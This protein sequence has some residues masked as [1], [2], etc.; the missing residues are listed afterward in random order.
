MQNIENPA[1]QKAAYITVLVSLVV[2]GL[3]FWAFYLT[4]SAAVFSDALETVVNVV[5]AFTGLAVISYT[6]KPKDE[7]H[8]YG[9]GKVEYFSAAFEGA[10]ILFASVTILVESVQVLLHPRELQ[11]L[12]LGIVCITVA[13]AINF[14]TALYLRRVG[15]KVKSETLMASSSHIMSD[16]WTTAGVVL[17]LALVRVTGWL[18]V[19]G[20]VTLVLA[21]VLM[22]E[23]YKIVRRSIS[24]L[25]DEMD[26]PSLS[27]LSESIQKNRRPGII[28]IHNLRTIRAGSFHH[29][30]AHLVVPE[31]WDVAQAHELAHVFEEAVVNDYPYDGEF[32]FHL[33]PCQRK[34]CRYCDVKN[35]PIRQEP[36]EEA[37]SF[38][39]KDMICG[40]LENVVGGAE[41]YSK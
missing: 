40:P 12:D 33:D 17:G 4:K 38:S 24:G 21:F 35:C 5:T 15:H 9:H 11:K 32:A 28:D 14:F 13:S 41:N 8:P 18:W 27:S 29:I 25:T 26:D 30:D 36:F 20:V 22:N 34:Y 2:L 10:L 7:D 1:R 39:V 16:V 37:R 19:D 31:F 3:K 6:V 23:G